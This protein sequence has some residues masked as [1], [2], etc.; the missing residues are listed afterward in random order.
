M[1]VPSAASRRLTGV[2]Q[3]RVGRARFGA[4]L[5]ALL[6]R[7]WLLAALLTAGLALRILAEA[8]YRPALLFSDSVRYLYLSGGNDPLGYRALLKPVLLVGNLD[9]VAAVQHLLGLGMAVA[10]Y[11]VLV[12][13]GA[14]RWL[15]ALATAPLLLDGYQ[16][17]MEQSVMSDVLFETLIVAALVILLWDS[18]PRTWMF[19]AAGFALGS[20]ATVRE[21]GQILI[22]PAAIYLLVVVRGWRVKLRQGTVLAVA[23]LLPILA[24]CTT[25]LAL[26]GHFRLANQGTNELYGRVVLAA[27]CHAVQLPADERPLCPTRQLA[28]K[29][30]NDALIHSPESPLRDFMPPGPRASAIAGDFTHRVFWQNPVGVFAAIGRDAAKLFAVT[31]VTDPGDTP[32]SRWQF[33]TF[34]PTYQYVSLQTVREAGKRYGGGGPIV[35]KPIA[36]FLR[37][38]QLDGGYTPGPLFLLC[39]LAGLAGSLGVLR[40]RSV[41]DAGLARCYTAGHSETAGA[42][43]ATRNVESVRGTEIVRDA[44]SVRDVESRRDA[45]SRRSAESRRDAESHRSAESRRD[46]RG[47]R[48]LSAACLLFF[49][50]AVILLLASDA[51]E[52]SWRYQLPAL[53]TLPPA[54]ALGIV[55]IAGYASGLRRGRSG[56]AAT[57]SAP[58]EAEHTSAAPS[59]RL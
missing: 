16:L 20:S 46:A 4:S 34:Y 18:R 36:A 30:G 19:A 47:G 51:F 5:S 35:Y 14:P 53:V 24:Y 42:V 32:I 21:I 26:T 3:A 48:D 1:G 45:E 7:H 8:A 15:A 23:F 2:G 25:S 17:Q 29:L 40:R 27:N 43:D 9:L 58:A 57:R 50:T 13:R 22:L 37:A 55:A 49:A 44:E 59:G 52:F 10:L 33:Q 54:G 11:I 56:D 31:R 39:T 6:R 38:Y 41:R 12:R 28:L